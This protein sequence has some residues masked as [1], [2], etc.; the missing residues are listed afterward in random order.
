MVSNGRAAM[1]TTDKQVPDWKSFWDSDMRAWLLKMELARIQDKLGHLRVGCPTIMDSTRDFI[2][3]TE[4]EMSGQTSSKSR[5]HLIF[6]AENAISGW[7]HGA[8]YNRLQTMPRK[9]FWTGILTSSGWSKTVRLNVIGLATHY[10]DCDQNLPPNF[11][12]KSKDI[13]FE[14][15]LRLLV[16]STLSYSIR[17]PR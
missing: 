14:P 10:I 11:E 2:F 5:R 7:I 17:F 9:S 3:I 8:R 6:I 12:Q 1:Q 13:M 4:N 16:L 15:G